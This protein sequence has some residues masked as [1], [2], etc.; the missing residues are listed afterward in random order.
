MT[1]RIHIPDTCTTVCLYPSTVMYAAKSAGL[2]RRMFI[3]TDTARLYIRLPDMTV[4]LLYIY[5]NRYVSE[6]LLKQMV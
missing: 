4:Y 3:L 2:Y 5:I 1:A 6:T